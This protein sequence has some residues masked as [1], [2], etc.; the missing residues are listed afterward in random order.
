MM[1]TRKVSNQ[2][3]SVELEK[4]EGSTKCACSKHKSGVRR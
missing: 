2:L 1:K 4:K 3:N